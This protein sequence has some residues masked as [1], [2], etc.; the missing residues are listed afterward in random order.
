MLGHSEIKVTQR[1]A[2]AMG[3]LAEGAARETLRVLSEL[4]KGP[5]VS[6]CSLMGPSEAEVFSLMGPVDLQAQG[7]PQAG[8]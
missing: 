1:Y 7:T 2:H 5:A 6:F 4:Q 3:T 8:A